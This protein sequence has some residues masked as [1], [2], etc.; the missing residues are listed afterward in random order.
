MIAEKLLSDGFWRETEGSSQ[1]ILRNIVIVVAHDA[2]PA[3][4]GI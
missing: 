4:I 3:V 2:H 1:N